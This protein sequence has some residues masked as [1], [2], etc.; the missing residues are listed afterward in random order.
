MALTKKDYKS[1]LIDKK[2]DRYI[3]VFGAIYIEGPK[4]CGKTWTSLNHSES[5]A[6]L[7]EKD[8][9]NL[10]ETNPK[11][12]FNKL[13][14]QLIDEWQ[15]VPEIWDAVRHECDEDSQKGKFILTGSTT[16]NKEESKRVYHSGAGRIA[17]LKMYTMSLYETGDSSRRC[18][19]N[20]YDKFHC[21]MWIY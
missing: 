4:W 16:L 12:I 21:Q 9:R 1:R 2:I 18:I 10:A 15:R 20:R 11:Y 17:R 5:V 3:E 19:Y 8:I 7:T 14:P 13:R 6:Y